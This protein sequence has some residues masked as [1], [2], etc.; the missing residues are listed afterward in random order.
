MD[1]KDKMKSMVSLL[2]RA[3]NAYYNL[4]K[5]FMSDE[6]YD[7]RFDELKALEK[8]TGIVL[9]DSPTHGVG[10]AVLDKLTK[11][12]INPPMLSLDKTQDIN[13]FKRFLDVQ[14]S[15]LMLKM[16]G[17][18][19]RLK[20]ENGNLVAANT[21]GNGTIG[22]SIIH[23]ARTF[24]NVPLKIATN[25]ELILDGEAIIDYATFDR[26]NST[27][28]EDEQFANPRNLVSG[29][30]RQLDSKVCADR[31]V[32]FICWK[33]IQ[34]DKDV[35]DFVTRLDYAMSLGFEVVLTNA[36]SSSVDAHKL[37]EITDMMKQLAT[38]SSYPIDGIVGKYISEAYGQSLGAT[39]HHENCGMAFKFKDKA[40]ETTLRDIEW[41]SGKTGTL[42][43]VAVFDSVQIE[44]TTV[45]RASLHNAKR[46]RELQIGIGDRIGI[47]KRNMIIPDVVENLT[48][49]NNYTFPVYC[50]CCGEPSLINDGQDLICENI[51]CKG[52]SLG[53]L[54]N[55]CGKHGMNIVGLS[56]ATLEKL[57]EDKM[58]TKFSDIYSLSQYADTIA[59]WDG[60]GKKSVDKL[61]RAIENSKHV[62]FH[63]FISALGIPMIGIAQGKILAKYFNYDIDAFEEAAIGF[64]DFIKLDNFGHT[65]NTNIHDWFYY[66][67]EEF[68]TLKNLMV[69]TDAVIPTGDKLFGKTFCTTGKLNVFKNRDEL[70]ASVESNG[71][72]Y[73]SGV[74]K[75]LNYLI[76]NETS[77]SSKM[78][79]AREL[80]V[81]V[82][83]EAEFLD[84]VK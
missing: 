8:E 52:K 51:K 78:K 30:V 4:A 47:V 79:K 6:E 45:S 77:E 65:L 32:R 76:S 26:I 56:E 66:N 53:L 33:V 83:T 84:M 7:K 57:Y 67:A 80:G 58:V 73:L 61:I 54:E 10:Y 49:S 39:A 72:T 27:L 68:N 74:S 24:V 2:N 63:Q 75:K 1:N 38:N 46:L 12:D 36:Y 3:R 31:S 82:I 21:R 69:F 19:V 18:S 64:F 50:P 13:E 62:S 15:F 44:G 25:E 43:P 14:P 16:D 34:M 48:R 81:E 5:P 9:K 28:P 70:I 22:E 41:S 17:L 20:Y 37:K 29:T 11:V 59:H 35:D 71:G 55:F 42:C 40:V 60:F 23:N